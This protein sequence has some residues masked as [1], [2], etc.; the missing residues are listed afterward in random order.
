M[1]MF[2]GHFFGIH[3]FLAVGIGKPIFL[4]I[5]S[6]LFLIKFCLLRKTV[7]IFSYYLTLN[8]KSNRK[9]DVTCVHNKKI[10][11]ACSN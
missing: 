3:L 8:P 2:L 5:Y 10:F 1:H 6:Y 9:F 7:F 4:P 11:A